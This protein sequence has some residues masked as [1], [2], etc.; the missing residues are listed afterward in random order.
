MY[1][2]SLNWNEPMDTK[3]YDLGSESECIVCQREKAESD[4]RAKQSADDFAEALTTFLTT[5]TGAI[6]KKAVLDIFLSS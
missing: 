3:F 4:E 2:V 1:A 5:D 6:R